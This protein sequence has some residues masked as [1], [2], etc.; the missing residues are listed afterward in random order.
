MHNITS[1]EKSQSEIKHAPKRCIDNVL[2]YSKALSVASLKNG[3]KIS[4]VLN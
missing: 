1:K 2:A 3:Q 4:M